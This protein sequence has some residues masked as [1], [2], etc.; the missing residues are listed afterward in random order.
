M[1]VVPGDQELPTEVLSIIPELCNFEDIPQ[2]GI[3]PMFP[4]LAGR[5]LTT[6]LPGKSLSK[7]L[8]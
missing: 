5:F 2:P 1:F 6:G 4:I 7:I 8:I 3:E